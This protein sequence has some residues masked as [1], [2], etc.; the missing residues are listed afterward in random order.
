VIIDY[1][2]SHDNRL[3]KGYGSPAVE[4]INRVKNQKERNSRRQEDI[5]KRLLLVCVKR[6][7]VKRKE[8]FKAN[9]R[10]CVIVFVERPSSRSNLQ[11]LRQ[12]VAAHI[13]FVSS[14]KKDLVSEKRK[15]TVCRKSSR[16]CVN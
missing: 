1:F 3:P 4:R 2:H 10:L 12:L 6:L 8:Q 15:V 9:K 11:T 16:L 13:D 7:C 14:D 5:S